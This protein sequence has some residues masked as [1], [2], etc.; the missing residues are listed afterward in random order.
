VFKC[1]FETDCPLSFVSWL[2]QSLDPNSPIVWQTK[3]WGFRGAS[4]CIFDPALGCL[5]RVYVNSVAN[6]SEVHAA[7][8]FGLELS[9]DVQILAQLTHGSK[10]WD[11]APSGPIGR[12]FK[13]RL[14]KGC[15]VFKNFLKGRC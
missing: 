3:Q 2:P 1:R 10:A 8:I 14:I 11:G 5:C 9:K 12:C 15:G 6:V 7:S 13:E 4:L